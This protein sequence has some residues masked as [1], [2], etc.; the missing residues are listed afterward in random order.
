MHLLRLLFEVLILSYILNTYIILGTDSTLNLLV[1]KN[2]SKGA[3]QTMWKFASSLVVS[4]H[5][6]TAETAS[7]TLGLG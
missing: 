4:Q 5:A 7:S 6:V 3:S 2:R 1:D